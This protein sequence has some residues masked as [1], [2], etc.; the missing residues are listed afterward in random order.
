MRVELGQTDLSGS[1]VECHYPGRDRVADRRIILEVIAP[2]T[3]VNELDDFEQG[4]EAHANV[5]E[6]SKRTSGDHPPPDR[7]T[8]TEPGLRSGPLPL[9]FGRK[10]V[11]EQS[12]KVTDG[13][14]LTC[15]RT[16]LAGSS[17]RPFGRGGEGNSEG[18]EAGTVAL[19]QVTEHV[20][21]C[22]RQV[23]TALSIG[24]TNRLPTITSWVASPKQYRPAAVNL[25][26]HP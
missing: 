4:G 23:T 5:H 25:F 13:A 2:M 11:A 26:F 22:W 8:D 16:A 7:L 14:H 10:V 21:P 12:L 20:A 6:D 15:L 9:L 17:R 3:R 18:G 19:G 1:I 24:S